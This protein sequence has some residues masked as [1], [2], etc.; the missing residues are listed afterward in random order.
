MN[1]IRKHCTLLI[2]AATCAT[3]TANAA[4]SYKNRYYSE[5]MGKW[6]SVPSKPAAVIRSQDLR[7]SFKKSEA[8]PTSSKAPENWTVRALYDGPGG[9]LLE[10]DRDGTVVYNSSDPNK[11]AAKEDYAMRQVF[12]KGKPIWINATVFNMIT[13]ST[14][15]APGYSFA[16]APIGIVRSAHGKYCPV[17]DIDPIKHQTPWNGAPVYI[18]DG[19]CDDSIELNLGEHKFLTYPGFKNIKEPY[20]FWSIQYFSDPVTQMYSESGECLRY[21]DEE[22]QKKE[23]ALRSAGN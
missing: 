14:E 7:S 17:R 12:A 23:A 15:D 18:L 10:F 11:T 8:I 2:I 1:M 3:A 13:K 19:T 16:F 21:C 9:D 4:P 20:F 6:Y 22:S 5:E